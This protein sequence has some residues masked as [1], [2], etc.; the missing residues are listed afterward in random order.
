MIHWWRW[1]TTIS[2]PRLEQRNLPPDGLCSVGHNI[3]S[4]SVQPVFSLPLCP[5]NLSIFHYF[6]YDFYLRSCKISY[7][8]Q[9]K[10]S[11]FSRSK[12]Y[13][14]SQW[15]GMPEG[16]ILPV[17]TKAK[18]HWAPQHFPC[19]LS[20]WPAFQQKVRIISGLSFAIEIS[21]EALLCLHTPCQIQL[22]LGFGFPHPIPAYLG[23]ASIYIFIWKIQSC[24]VG[25]IQCEQHMCGSIWLEQMT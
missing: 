7:G 3:L 23:S 14:G 9:D 1:Y 11:L 5:V 6:V 8:S 10:H 15:P 17:K 20:M 13:S 18:S 21:V 16:Q 4:L 25:N 12:I 2:T 24:A 19:P 22:S